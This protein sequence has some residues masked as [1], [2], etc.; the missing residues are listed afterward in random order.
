MWMLL[1]PSIISF[2]TQVCRWSPCGSLAFYVSP[3]SRDGLGFPEPGCASQCPLQSSLR[4]VL[5]G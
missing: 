4:L 2:L 5:T 1:F 3:P